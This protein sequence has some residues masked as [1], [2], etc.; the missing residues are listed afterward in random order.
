MIESM[1]LQ[2]VNQI[3]L[4]DYTDGRPI[5]IINNPSMSQLSFNIQ[6]NVNSD[7]RGYLGTSTMTN[8][9]D[10]VI[11]D[12]TILMALWS[13]LYGIEEN[14]EESKIVRGIEYLSLD[15]K[16]K[17][18]LSSEFKGDMYL[19]SIDDNIN[20]IVPIR[21]YTIEKD[22]DDKYTIISFDSGYEIKENYMASYLYEIN[23][24]S[25]VKVKQIHEGLLCS[26][27]IYMSGTDLKN[28]DKHNAIIH[29]NKVQVN[30]DFVI[31]IN[32]SKNASFTPIHVRSIPEASSN[33]NKDVAT[34]TIL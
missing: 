33:I 17:L 27:D 4:S 24:V 32:D 2:E 14:K 13:K 6:S 21:D 9:L 18:H 20:T 28:D 11:N 8:N 23:P 22:D 1:R 31:S 30:T 12:G 26:L 29:C 10:F 16:N 7:D 19:Y 5:M 3:V 25:V 34:M 15:E